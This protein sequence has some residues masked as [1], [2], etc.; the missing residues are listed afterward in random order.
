MKIV[1]VGG[2]VAGL[3]CGRTLL[4][5]G[6]EVILLEAS[7]G[8]G[9]R[10]RSD[11]VEGFTFDRG[12]QVLF[13]AYPAAQRQLEYSKL[14]FRTFEPG[15]IISKDRK[16]Y[17]LS[18][19]LRN[20][21]ALV[22]SILSDIVSIKDKLQTVL[23]VRE[24]ISKSIHELISGPDQTT[25]SFLRGKGF[26]DKYI[27]NF[28]RPFYGGIFLDN[29][30]N[31]SAKAFKFDFKMLSQGQTVVPAGG[32]GQISEQLAQELKDKGG[33]RLKAKVAEVVRDENGLYSGARLENGEVIAGDAVVVATS[34]P[35]A[36]RLTGKPMP[37][38]ETSTVNL[39]FAG[40]AP[41]YQGKKLVLNANPNPF[42]NNTVQVTNIAPDYAPSGQYLLSATV[43]GK[44]EG[45]DE[46]LYQRAMT[47]LRRI[48]RG[49]P[50]A[51]V[52]LTG[53]RPL[54]IY[55]IP[56][57]QF[58]QPPGLHPTL[59]DNH[60]GEPRLFFAAEFTEASSIN[61][62]MISGEKAAKLIESARP[63]M[64]KV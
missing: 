18:D 46:E 34:A 41:L 33:L 29:S 51:E 26:S 40:T 35:E 38:G 3:V 37:T 31:T 2:G 14:A 63:L 39:Y 52:A 49:D 53:Y 42:V 62:A 16:R 23:L 45:S 10:V 13:T 64:P 24:V 58:A 7:D 1:I 20:P 50:H 44:P 6:H 56:Y 36:A 59:P 28:V 27:N 11:K 8:V 4:R 48:F 5:K 21:S 25:E 43:L 57:G 55:R 61:G 17:V 30:L 12:F 32:M 47:D 54:A 19:P 22:P 15:A 60:S 9:G